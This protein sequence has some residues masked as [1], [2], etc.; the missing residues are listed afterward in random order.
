MTNGRANED[1]QSS[2][3]TLLKLVAALAILFV[4]VF[5]CGCGGFLFWTALGS[6]WPI[7]LAAF[8]E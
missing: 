2:P 7:D 4:F 3:T 6:P 5:G 1:P 8:A